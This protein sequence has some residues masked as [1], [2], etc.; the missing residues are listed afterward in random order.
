MSNELFAGYNKAKMQDIT[1]NN[2]DNSDAEIIPLEADENGTAEEKSQVDVANEALAMFQGARVSQL[3]SRIVSMHNKRAAM[4]SDLKAD[5]KISK[6]LRRAL[7][8]EGVID[9]GETQV[10]GDSA[11]DDMKDAKKEADAE[12]LDEKGASEDELVKASLKAQCRVLGALY[13]DIMTVK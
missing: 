11:A 1:V 12:A 8:E 9:P 5:G 7:L 6:T 3:K 4:F 10:I 13:K 2:A